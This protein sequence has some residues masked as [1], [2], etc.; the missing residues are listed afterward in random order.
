MA[1]RGHVLLIVLLALIPV[2]LARA[3]DCALLKKQL[4]T[5]EQQH[6]RALKVETESVV[7]DRCG[8]ETASWVGGPAGA[9]RYQYLR[10]RRSARR[11]VRRTWEQDSP[12]HQ[13]LKDARVSVEQ[14]C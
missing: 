2:G 14:Q 8:P 4:A 7:E 1:L 12:E 6:D 11:Q 13:L 5:I 10:C 9:Q 3:S